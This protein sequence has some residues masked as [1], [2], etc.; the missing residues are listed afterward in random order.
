[1][2][3]TMAW[4]WSMAYSANAAAVW[5]GVG[6]SGSPVRLVVGNTRSARR[7]SLAALGLALQ[8]VLLKQNI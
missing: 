1:V 4:A 3:I 7:V 6:A 5:G 8:V 2:S